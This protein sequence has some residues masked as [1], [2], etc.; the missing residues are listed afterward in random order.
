MNLLSVFLQDTQER[1]GEDDCPVGGFGFGLRDD[2]FPF[3]SVN[4]PFHPQ[5]PGL[6]IEI[7]PLEGQKLTS[8]QA[9]GDLQ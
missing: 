1:S 5:R 6:E 9:S 8:P 7:V 2:Q 3:G 4:L